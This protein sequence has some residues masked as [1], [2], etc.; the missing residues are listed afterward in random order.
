MSWAQ[1]MAIFASTKRPESSKLFVSWLSSDAYQKTL[2]DGGTWGSRSDIPSGPNK[3][4]IFDSTLTEPIGFNKF[5]LDRVGVEWW[6]L[7]YETILG[8]PQGASPLHDEL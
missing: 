3:T 2:A 4:N 7:Q 6:R 8:M 5:M 1:T